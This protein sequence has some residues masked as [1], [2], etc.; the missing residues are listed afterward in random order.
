MRR[1]NMGFRRSF[2][3]VVT[4]IMWVLVSSACEQ[5]APPDELIEGRPFPPLVL[6]GFDGERQ[7]LDEYRGKFVILNI[8]ATW[9]APCRVELPSL[10][11]LGE[12]LDPGKFVVIGLSVDSD[13]EIAQEFY[14]DRGI[15]F[16]SFIDPDGKISEG[17][18]GIRVYPDTFLISPQGRLL[19]R[20]VGER[21]W[22]DPAMIEALNRAYAGDTASLEKI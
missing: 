17:L 10:D 1:S 11:R 14:R 3:L 2:T 9:C 19:R 20:I 6:T 15:R 13:L 4:L 5:T 16:T 18:L 7:S 12:A 8:W 22:D 21:V